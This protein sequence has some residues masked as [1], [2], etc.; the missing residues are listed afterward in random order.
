MISFFKKKKE[1]TITPEK[2][3]VYAPVSG[4]A[5]PLAEVDDKMF[6]EE[7]LGKGLAIEP[8][9]DTIYAPVSGRI[10]VAPKSC[11]AIGILSPDGMEVLIHVGINTVNLKGKYFKGFASKGDEVHAGQKLIEF[12]RK[13]V[14]EAGYDVITPVIITNSD[15]Y[16]E[17]STVTGKEVSEFE[18]VIEVK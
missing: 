9:S 11:H 6:A 10:T 5:K 18:K 16:E 12:D 13:A 1:F 2:N 7:L 4:T 17:V 8:D 14:K 15:D 3:C